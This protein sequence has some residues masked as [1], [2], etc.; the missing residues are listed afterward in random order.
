MPNEGIASRFGRGKREFMG[1]DTPDDWKARADA[2]RPPIQE[3]FMGMLMRL[4]GDSPD[5]Q[6]F[7]LK[8]LSKQLQG[9]AIMQGPAAQT[10][11]QMMQRFQQL[12]QPNQGQQIQVPQDFTPEMAQ[13]LLYGRGGF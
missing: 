12:Q 1:T 7:N 3:G 9:L 8:A 10:S 13:M 4:F 11:P 5:E 6:E 2:A